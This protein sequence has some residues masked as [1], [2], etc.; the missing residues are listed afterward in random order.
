MEVGLGWLGVGVGVIGSVVMYLLAVSAGSDVEQGDG[1][2]AWMASGVVLILTLIFWGISSQKNAP[3]SMGQTLGLGF[4]IGG[5]TGAVA[6]LVAMKLEPAAI[7]SA[8][9]ASLG[10]E[11][12]AFLGL[13]G[14][15]LAYVLF[16]GYPQ[17]ALIGFSIG[18]A[19]AGIIHHL[20]RSARSSYPGGLIA[21][22]TFF[23]VTTAA[24]VVLAIYHFDNDTLRAWWPLPIL[25]AATVCIASYI[26]TET[27]SWGR[28][29]ERPGAGYV[30]S[31]IVGAVITIGL[32]AIYSARVVESWQLLEVTAVG[33]GITALIAWLAASNREDADIP[34]GVESAAGAVLLVVAGAVVAFKLWTG[35]G[36]GIGLIAGWT[37]LLTAV[38][39][40]G[41]LNLTR[42]LGSAL[43]LGLA[44][45]LFRVFIETYR[46]EL[47][48]TDLRIH[49]T[50]IGA[51]L[52]AVLPFIFA[53][54]LIRLRSITRSDAGALLGVLLLGLFAAALPIVLFAIWEIKAV[55]G[56]VFGLIAAEAFLMMGP[57]TAPT[58]ARDDTPWVVGLL[59]IGAQLVA[60]QF[61]RPLIDWGATRGTKI[62]ILAG[63]LLVGLLWLGVTGLMA[64]R[65]AR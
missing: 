34:A 59:V 17:E 40:R 30:L 65:R 18:A 58:D 55:L 35:L 42:M 24:S 14:A 27:G 47:G 50:F 4:L 21:I 5:V 60:V 56:L 3:F 31:L 38:G 61:V 33:I 1:R 6:G 32:A 39:N 52:G 63:A 8:R 64:R 54:S 22:W 16:H 25:M 41:S 23:S 10:A 51:L 37:A 44:I 29:R 9:A 12:M 53:T 15:S 2:R 11:C 48:T 20:L 19:M 26:G 43:S 45:V 62:W 13:L 46:P 57:V 7:A 49:Y 28:L 36:I